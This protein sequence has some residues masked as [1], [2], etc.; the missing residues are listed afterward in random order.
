MNTHFNASGSTAHLLDELALYGISSLDGERDYRPMPDADETEMKITVLMQTMADL[1]HDTRLEDETEEMLWSVVNGFHRRTSHIQKKLNDNADKI[2][3]ANR[4]YDGSEIRDVEMQKLI[5]EGRS[6]EEHRNAFELMRDRASEHFA[7]IT[8]K[9]WLPRTGSKVSHTNMTATA[10]ESRQYLSAKRHKE[11]SASCPEGT[12]I[13]FSGGQDYA[14]V[15]AIWNALDKARTKYPDMILMHGGSTKGAEH[16][17]SLWAANRGVHQVAFKPD[18]SLGRRAP[19]VRNDL[20]L[21]EGPQGLI[22][23]P[24]GGIQEQIIRNAR[25]QGIVVWNLGA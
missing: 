1:F 14:N 20:M 21:A 11:T 10:L 9:P 12:R 3:D 13:V 25:Q 6:F 22:V 18:Y 24:G 16:I 5:A 17:A 19:F 23:A 8:G 7:A 4:Q 15:D 2:K